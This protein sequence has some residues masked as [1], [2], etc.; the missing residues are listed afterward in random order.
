MKEETNGLLSLS[1]KS[2]KKS[3]RDSKIDW[4]FAKLIKPSNIYRTLTPDYQPVIP[5]IVLIVFIPK[6]GLLQDPED[7]FAILK[8]LATL[9]DAACNL[10][11]VIGIVE[12]MKR[13]IVMVW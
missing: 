2:E 9:K 4:V 11:E 6:V 13:C 10:A 1:F 7:Q 8:I 12:V 5:V 3:L